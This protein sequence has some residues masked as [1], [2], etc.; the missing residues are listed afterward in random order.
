MADHTASALS[1]SRALAVAQSRLDAP[2]AANQQRVAH[3]SPAP[4]AHRTIGATNSNSTVA[5]PT[6]FQ[7]QQPPSQSQALSA[8]QSS[9]LVIQLAQL[10]QVFLLSP[11][12]VMSY[13]QLQTTLSEL[14]QLARQLSAHARHAAVPASQLSQVEE[15]RL[16]LE[17]RKK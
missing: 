2:A 12:A 9:A 3:F 1:I 17:L 10:L 16:G 6:Q 14:L 15:E 4:S 8:A 7:Q 5:S 13:A 11:T